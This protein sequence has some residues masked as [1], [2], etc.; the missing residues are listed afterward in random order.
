[1]AAPVVCPEAA[2]TPILREAS[3]ADYDRIAALLERNGLHARAPREWIRL[4]EGNPAYEDSVA[5]WPIG[6]V[7]EASGQQ[8]VGSI[9]N[10]PGA[11]FWKG[12][13]LQ[14]ATECDWAVDERFR[15]YSLLLL[16]KL[17]TQPN[18][19]LVLT[20]TAGANAEPGYA[21]LQWS[22][23]PVGQWDHAAFWVTDYHGFAECALRTRM[24]RLAPSIFEYPLSAALACRDRFWRR[25][26]GAAHIAVERCAEFDPRFD[27]FWEQLK[28][29][30]SRVLMAERSRAALTWHLPPSASLWIGAVA[31][32]SAL[33]AYGVFIRRDNRAAGLKRVRLVDFQCLENCEELL[34]AILGWAL[35]RCRAEGVHVLEDVG[36]LVQR[37]GFPAVPKAYQR[38]LDSWAYYYKA[39][40]NELCTAL[41]E[42]DCWEPSCFDGDAS[43][44]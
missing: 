13:R 12:M 11:Y 15:A 25:N 27:V 28:K 5:H 41:R 14:A 9:V 7:L 3:F 30:K 19:D 16:Q 20:T 22:R 1:M 6:W 18:V 29:R 2:S 42:P 21:A 33:V 24:G 23:V 37:L 43:L 40:P 17:T 10:V 36:C 34:G 35:E 31:R 8:I 39:R 26:G 4:W 44:P 32:A 38:P